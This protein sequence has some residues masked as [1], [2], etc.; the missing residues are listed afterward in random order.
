[1]AAGKSLRFLP[2]ALWLAGLG[3]LGQAYAWALGMMPYTDP[4]EVNVMLQD[5]DRVIEANESTGLLTIAADR[6]KRKTR[7]AAARLEELGFDTFITERRFDTSTQP[8]VAFGEPVTILAG[9]DDLRPRRQLEG[10]GFSHIVD[11]GLGTGEVHYLD[12]LLHTFPGTTRAVDAFPERVRDDSV[13]PENLKDEIRRLVEAGVDPQ[14]AKCGVMSLYGTAAA[15]AFVG[16]TA[17]ALVIGDV[18]RAIHGGPRFDATGF[19]L[20]TLLLSTAEA[21]TPTTPGV[22]PTVPVEPAAEQGAEAA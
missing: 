1:M 22:I 3:H 20:R 16:A 14:Q 18:L 10:G 13:L 21:T 11:A 9:F 19:S 12:M 4:H 17:A 2:R 6:E 15:A 5:Y 7:V 8:D